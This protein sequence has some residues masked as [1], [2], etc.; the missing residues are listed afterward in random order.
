L[1]V[2]AR[3][4]ILGTFAGV[5][6]DRSVYRGVFLEFDPKEDLRVELVGH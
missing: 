1:R 6:G 4:N 5:D 2:G 3:A